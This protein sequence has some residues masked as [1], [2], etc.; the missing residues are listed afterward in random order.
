MLAAICVST[1]RASVVKYK[2][3][4]LEDLRDENGAPGF[5][6]PSWSRQ[7]KQWVRVK[8]P[9]TEDELER[10]HKH[11]VRLSHMPKYWLYRD[12]FVVQEDVSSQPDEFVDL[13][14]SVIAEGPFI[15]GVD[16]LSALRERLGS[17]R[18]RDFFRLS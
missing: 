9:V 17:W 14:Q 16:R 12:R 4:V 3:R 7:R 18:K 10:Q 13:L 1:V 15:P 8:V 11:P 2:L 6:L 5:S